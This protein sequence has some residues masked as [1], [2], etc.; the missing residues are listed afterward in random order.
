MRPAD[1]HSLVQYLG[2]TFIGAVE[3]PHPAQ[4]PGREPGGI[5]ICG[6]QIFR[7]GHRRAL[8]RPAADQPAYL[9][10]QLHLRQ[11]CRDQLV[12]RRKHSGVI[13][14][15]SDVH[16]FFPL[17]SADALYFVLC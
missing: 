11:S 15:L 5:M 10:V 6:A 3:F 9:T 8:L 2:D 12:Q 7:R 13:N 17:S 1:V 4:I 14:S 16:G